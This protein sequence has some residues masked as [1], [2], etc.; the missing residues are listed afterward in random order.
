MSHEP[1]DAEAFRI[2]YHEFLEELVPL[3]PSSRAGP[4]A[5]AEALYRDPLRFPP[6][7]D[8][9]ELATAKRNFA[10]LLS[11]LAPADRDVH[12]EIARS[13]LREFFGLHTAE[14]Q[15]VGPTAW[16]SRSSG[17]S[18]SPPPASAGGLGDR[19]RSAFSAL[20]RGKGSTPQPDP[21]PPP[22]D[23]DG[24]WHY[25]AAAPSPVP[26]ASSE[27]ARGAAAERPQDGAPKPH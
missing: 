27:G 11:G 21:A 26:L 2:A 8:R 15:V 6:E 20:V 1:P 9:A 5:W 25:E 17:P 24:S 4:P 14:T 23:D 18:V 13:E 12:R 16:P 10:V 22:D 3:A 7:L 19:L